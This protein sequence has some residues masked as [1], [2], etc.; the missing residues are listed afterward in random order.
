VVSPE[1]HESAINVLAEGTEVKGTLRVSDY[2]RIHGRLIGDLVGE[3]GS[4]VVLGESGL[5]EGKL[6]VDTVWIDGCVR[7]DIV[8]TTRVSISGSGRVLGNI[9]T[10]SLI[11]EHG[12]HFEGMNS[13][14]SMSP[15]AT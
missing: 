12:A 7:G 1:I 13:N 3:P 5:I 6:A 14:P 10:P 2:S 4:I 8:A 15:A 9:R 11:I